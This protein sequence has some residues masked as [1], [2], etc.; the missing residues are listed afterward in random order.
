M[1]IAI[2]APTYP[3]LRKA[4]EEAIRTAARSGIHPSTR[5]D[6]S[7]GVLHFL[8]QQLGQ[9]LP[10]PAYF[11]TR[12]VDAPFSPK[13]APTEIKYDEGAPRRVFMDRYE[14]NPRARARC[15][16]HHGTSCAA[17]GLSLAHRY[18]PEAEGLIHVH[19]RRPRA[20]VRARSTINPVRD[21]V[22]VCPNCHAVIHRTDPPISI[23]KIQQMLEQA[24]S[25]SDT[26]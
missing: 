2:V 11:A 16:E 17:C 6:H 26:A 25:R 9:R 12:I 7:P 19:H 13:E 23:K 1:G 14:R 21:L 24:Q 3:M 10:E 8:S 5:K 4:H 22:P 18:G 20:S 15:I